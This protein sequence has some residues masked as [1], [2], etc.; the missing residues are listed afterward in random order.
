MLNTQVEEHVEPMV[1][2]KGAALI[3]CVSEG[4]VRTW[5]DLGLI[6]VYRMGIRGGRRFKV[7][8]LKA[9]ME[10]CKQVVH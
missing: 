9:Y 2:V 4:T 3:L 1:D 5:S 7:K 6:P 8:D 10:S